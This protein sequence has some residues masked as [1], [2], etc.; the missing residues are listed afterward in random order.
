MR[1][2]TFL[3]VMIG[4]FGLSTIAKGV[5]SADDLIK[6]QLIKESIASYSGNCPCPFNSDRRGRSCGRRSAYSRGGGKTPICYAIDVTD[7]M[8]KDFKARSKN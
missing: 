7:E 8:I 2:N 4:I 5:D 3:F 6:K 1:A